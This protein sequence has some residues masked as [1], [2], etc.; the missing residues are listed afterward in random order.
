MSPESLDRVRFVTRYFNE[1]QG[2]RSF[3]P[4]GLFFFAKGLMDFF[5]SP[6]TIGVGCALFVG[7][8]FLWLGARMYYRRLGEVESRG[9]ER[10]VQ[11]LSLFHPEGVPVT[12]AT[13]LRRVNARQQGLL[14]TG[15]VVLYLALRAVSPSVALLTD[16]SGID[17]WLQ[18]DPPVVETYMGTY[19]GPSSPGDWIFAAVAV[20]PQVLYLATGVLLLS[21][22]CHR[23]RRPSQS[24]YLV[25]GALLLAFA[26]LGAGLGL[27]M[28]VLWGLGMGQFD[29]LF[30]LPLAHLW[31]AQLL[32]GAALIL[33]GL[34]DHL[35]LVRILRPVEV[36]R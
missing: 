23:E 12:L 2:L 35:Q 27:V 24:L 6:L 14:L 9:F 10:T 3:V 18:L 34:A 26:F 13:P 33:C 31:L 4:V 19:K 36:S 11:I 28:P 30:L 21:I 5:P 32:C 7:A 16:H 20:L 25:L 22:W 29:T 15:A 17:P 8:A 1:L